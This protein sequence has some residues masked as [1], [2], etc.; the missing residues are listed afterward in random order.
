MNE[1]IKREIKPLKDQYLIVGALI[2]IF[3][4]LQTAFKDSS[5]NYILLGLILSGISFV[6]INIIY[7]TI[8][9]Q[10][11]EPSTSLSS[12]IYSF[13]L[14]IFVIFFLLIVYQNFDKV[15]LFMCGITFGFLFTLIFAKT[16]IY[17]I[18]FQ[19]R[20]NSKIIKKLVRIIFMII[21]ISIVF[22]LLRY[23]DYNSGSNLKN[24]L[25]VGEI[26]PFRI[27]ALTFGSILSLGFLIGF[28]VL[29]IDIFK[30]EPLW[31]E[32]YIW[33]KTKLYAIKNRLQNYI[34]NKK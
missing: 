25:E 19:K 23:L 32:R 11:K 17:L 10:S 2:A 4:L 34:K 5:I 22:L 29:L 28:I 1:F 26:T 27:F 3:T 18:I 16:R 6:F 24:G 14:V 9:I 12:T 33:E 15:F 21:F 8:K 30:K 13:S 20:L 7:N 31:S